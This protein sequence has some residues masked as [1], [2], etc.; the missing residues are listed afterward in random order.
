MGLILSTMA[1]AFQDVMNSF[2][3][4]PSRILMLGLDA[5]GKTTVLYKLKMNE[6]VATIPTLGFNVETIQP[7][8]N[9]SFTVWDIG[10]QHKIRQLWKHYYSGTQGLVYVV[11]A[12]DRERFGEAKNELNWILDSEEMV[13]VPLVILANK[14]DLP[15]AATPSDLAVSLGLDK[16]RNRKWHVQGTS[17]LSG[18]GIYEAMKELSTLVKDF[19]KHHPI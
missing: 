17:A 6:T 12:V 5:A 10:G 4:K 8:K 1:S 7:V 13:G 9:V 2:S 3:D 16:L 18:D 19:Q 11:D 15:R 14:Q